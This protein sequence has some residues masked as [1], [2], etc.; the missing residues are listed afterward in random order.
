MVFKITGMNSEKEAIAIDEFLKAR[1]FVISSSTDFK[2]GLCKV[3][4]DKSENKAKIIEAICYTGKK[5]G[6]KI[7]AELM[8]NSV[9]KEQK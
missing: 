5:F 9:E 7:T 6:N 4:T 8:D 1:P 2:T 3:E